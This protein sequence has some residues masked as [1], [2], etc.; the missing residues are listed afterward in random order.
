MSIL[1]EKIRKNRDILDGAEP[2]EGHSDRFLE[3]LS[4]LHEQEGPRLKR[5]RFNYVRIAAVAAVLVGL[6]MIVYLFDPAGIPSQATAGALPQEIRDAKI[7]YENLAE[8]KLEKIN[9]CAANTSEASYIQ[10]TAQEQ[11][12]LIDSNT[13]K[14]EAELQKDQNNKHLINALVRNYKTKADLMN[15]ILNKLCH[16]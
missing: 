3:K 1:E 15:D 6:S 10:K 12:N 14:L 9:E 7:Y 16:I 5:S 4:A 2:P 13:V 11:I 8:E